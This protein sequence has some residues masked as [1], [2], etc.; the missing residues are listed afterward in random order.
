VD[1]V[2]DTEKRVSIRRRS[3][4]DDSMFALI[5][6]IGDAL[7]RPSDEMDSMNSATL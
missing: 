4:R 3:D 7:L 2:S 1:Y 5:N 6:R